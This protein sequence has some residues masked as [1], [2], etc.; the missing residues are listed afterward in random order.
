MEKKYP[1]ALSY[2]SF[3]FGTEIKERPSEQ[4]KKVRVEESHLQIEI[5]GQNRKKNIQ[6]RPLH[7]GRN[8][9]SGLVRCKSQSNVEPMI[10]KAK[11]KKKDLEVIYEERINTEQ[12]R[13]SNNMQNSRPFFVPYRPQRNERVSQMNEYVRQRPTSERKRKQISEMTIQEIQKSFEQFGYEDLLDLGERIGKVSTGLKEE[14][15]KK[16]PVEEYDKKLH[17]CEDCLFCLENFNE[18]EK[19]MKLRCKHIF[20]KECLIKYFQEKKDCPMCKAEV[21]V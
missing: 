15:I 13:M 21:V 17:K 16:I 5:P 14:K 12:S 1:T 8:V 7:K 6:K 4:K 2:L 20:H 18:G 11:R 10:N 9:N 19:I 3:I